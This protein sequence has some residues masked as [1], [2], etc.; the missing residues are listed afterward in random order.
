MRKIPRYVS[1]LA[2]RCIS[3]DRLMQRDFPCFLPFYH[4]VSD[5]QLPHVL[6]YPYRDKAA[7]EKELDFYLQYF[8]PVALEELAQGNHSGK[9]VFHLSFDDGLRECAEIIA[10]ILLKKGIPATFFI[11]TGFAGNQDLFYRYKASLI[12]SKLRKKPRGMVE[13]ILKAH[14]LQGLSLLKVSHTEMH[15]LRDVA[16]LLKIDFEK[17]LRKKQPYLTWDQIKQLA[18]S[19]FSIGAHSHDHPEF[20]KLSPEEQ[21]HQVKTS[22]EKVVETVNPPIK[23]FSFPFTDSGVNGSVIRKIK[24]EGICDIT[25]GTAGIKH[26][27][28]DFHYQRYPAEQEGDFISNLKTEIVYYEL[29]KWIGK[30]TVR[31]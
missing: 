4:V 1:R 22:M 18:D 27:V 5:K 25:F 2:A 24:A 26:D 14:H 6:N 11:N 9:K 12:L 7:F 30:S 29:R 3:V 13:K 15:M 16:M 19:G 23:T 21:I 31:H 28:L 10:P 20:W 8:K 17:Y